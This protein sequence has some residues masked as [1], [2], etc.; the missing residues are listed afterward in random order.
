M[1][2]DAETPARRMMGEREDVEW[3]RDSNPQA[4][5]LGGLGPQL[6]HIR[7]Q[8]EDG[9]ADLF[10]SGLAPSEHERQV[11]RVRHASESGDPSDS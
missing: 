3:L 2:G 9:S 4:H 6:S 8:N 10:M 5:H 1:K 11:L 7:D